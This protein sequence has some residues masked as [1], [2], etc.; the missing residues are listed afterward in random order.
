MNLVAG[1][2]N[3]LPEENRPVALKQLSFQ[4]SAPQEAGYL[5]HAGSLPLGEIPGVN[6]SALEGVPSMDRNGNLY[7]VSTRSYDQTFSTIYRT[8][9]VGGAAG[10]PEI[11]EGA[12]RRKPGWVNFDAEISADGKTL[13]FVDAYFGSAGRPQKTSLVVAAAAGK[14]LRRRGD[15]AA[16]FENVNSDWITYAPDVSAVS[17]LFARDLGPTFSRDWYC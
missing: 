4:K 16:V 13:Y 5:M 9:F 3:G 15:S 14:G 17:Y 7:F 11:V 1:G 8:R 12:S 2:G 10:A 6:T